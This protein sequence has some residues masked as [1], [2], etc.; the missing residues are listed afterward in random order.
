MISISI[1][2]NIIYTSGGVC[3]AQGFGANAV[4]CDGGDSTSPDLAIVAGEKACKAAMVA[5]RSK[6]NGASLKATR[7]LAR[8]KSM[9]AIIITGK[10]ANCYIPDEDMNAANYII[11]RITSA[12]GAEQTGIGLASTGIIGK[13]IDA[14]RIV[15]STRRLV[16]GLSKTGNDAAASVL[17]RDSN[18][19][20]QYAVKFDIKKSHCVIGGMVTGGNIRQHDFAGNLMILTTDVNISKPFLNAAL[21]YAGSRTFEMIGMSPTVNDMVFIMSSGAAENKI[22][23]Q[24]G[25]D[26]D[27]FVNALYITMLNLSKQLVKNSY[28]CSKLVE[29]VVKNAYNEQTAKNIARSVVSSGSVM[30]ALF[31]PEIPLCN[32]VYYVGGIEGEFER[33]ELSIDISSDVGKLELCKNGEILQ[34]KQEM[35]EVVPSL[36][37]IRITI[38]AGQGDYSAIAWG[39]D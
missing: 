8:R 1:L 25:D 34:F 5:T 39:G 29:C 20:N 28:G 24:R 18:Q 4:C 15:G 6:F 33:E 14:D 36:D 9:K 27:M 17:R 21:R 23:N 37:E 11:T 31:D 16:L 38:E 2:D 35:G 26:Y 10:N 13:P 3:A 12:L 22:I 32:L 30:S 7:L 19:K